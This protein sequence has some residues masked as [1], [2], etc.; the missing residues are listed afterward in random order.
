MFVADHLLQIA[1]KIKRFGYCL[2]HHHQEMMLF[3][4]S[5]LLHDDEDKNIVRLVI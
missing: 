1:D 5:T 2:C 3:D 4:C